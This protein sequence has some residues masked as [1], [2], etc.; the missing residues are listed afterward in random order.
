[1]TELKARESLS[2]RQQKCVSSLSCSVMARFE[3]AF[4]TAKLR[5]AAGSA[6]AEGE[7]ITSRGSTSS[8][9]MTARQK[10]EGKGW[11]IASVFHFNLCIA[12]QGGSSGQIS[13]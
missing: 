10:E 8:S 12:V 3:T 9:R 5:A 2:V 11:G 6:A 13:G 1:M 4:L 7:P